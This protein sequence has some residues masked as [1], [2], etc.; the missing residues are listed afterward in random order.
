VGRKSFFSFSTLYVCAWK[1]AGASAEVESRARLG[2]CRRGFFG[3]TAEKKNSGQRAHEAKIH[4]AKN[5][6]SRQERFSA[7]GKRAFNHQDTKSTTRTRQDEQDWQ[8]SRILGHLKRNEF[9]HHDTKIATE[10]TEVTEEQ[11]N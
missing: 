9:D 4:L 2:A 10:A 1:K 8:G 7:T 5:I 3:N 6:F 11:L